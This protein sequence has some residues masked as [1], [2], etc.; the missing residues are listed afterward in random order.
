EPA[1]LAETDEVR[2]TPEIRAL[3]AKLGNHPVQ[4]YN[5]ARNNVRYTPGYG[6]MQGSAATLQGLRGN[7][8]DTAS[9]L[10]AL[11]RAAGIPSRFVYG[12]VEVPLARMQRWLGV[13]DAAA[14]QALLLAAGI[15]HQSLV[16]GGQIAAI[17]FEHVWVRAHADFSPSRGA[18]GKSAGDWVSLDASFKLSQDKAALDLR[19]AV[20]LNEP[21]L[22]D[23][24][25]AG[26]TCLPDQARDL[27]TLTLESGYADFQN[28]LDGYL[29]QQGPDLSV[30]DVLGSSAIGA[31]NFSILLGTLP[32]KTIAVG[33]VVQAL[34]HALRWQYRFQLFA[35]G[36]AQAQGQA[37]AELRGSFAEL[38]GKRITLSFAPASEA[39]AATLA[40]YMPQAHADGSAIA[41]AEFPAGLP[42]YLIRL[43]AEL[44]ADGVLVSSG[45]SFVPGSA[46]LADIGAFEP[47]TGGW[48]ERAVTV[49]AGDYHAVAIDA[50]GVAGARLLEVKAR[51][52][53]TAGKVAA[54]QAASLSRDDLAGDVLYQTALAFFATADAN[55][56]VF[57]R[58]ANVVAQRLP[59]YGRA[60]APVRAYTMLGIINRIDFP[61]VTL[62]IDRMDSAVAART[63]GLAPAAFQRQSN[64]RDA[65]YARLVL[66]KMFTDAQHPA[67]TV[68]AINALARASQDGQTIHA[69]TPA[70]LAAVLPLLTLRANAKAALVDAVG[71]GY[72]VLLARAPVG[73]GAWE[74][75]ALQIED[76]AT[77]AGSYQLLDDVGEATANVFP[78]LGMGW[79]AL[80]QP[81]QSGAALMP[82]LAAGQAIDDTLAGML[83]QATTRWS[84]FAG[85]AD[86]GNGMFLARLAAMQG[87]QACDTVVGILAAN[88]GTA[89]G[90][91]E[92][93]GDAAAVA[94]PV[95]TS[96]PVGAA[97][98][99][100]AYRYAATFNDPR[101]LPLTWRLVD[102]PAGMTVN[103]AGLVAWDKPVAGMFAVTLRADNGRAYAD[104]RYVV[105]V[106]AEVLPLEISLAITPAIV[107]PGDTVTVTMLT[108]GGSG[109]ATATVTVDGQPV[110]L[111]GAGRAVIGAGAPGAHQIVVRATDSLGTIEKTSFY[112]VRV[113]GDIT[114]PLSA[115]TS[116]A[117]DVEVTAPVNIVG[118]AFD[119]NL[120]YY[121]LLLRPAGDE[122]WQEIGRGTASVTAGVLGKLD[123]T[124][125]HNGIYELALNVVDAN[126]AKTS[127]LVTVDIYRDMKIGQFAITFEDLNVEAAG[128]PIRVTRTYD[129]R[130]KGEN[131]DFGYGW[132]VDYQSVQVRKNMVLG[133]QWKLERRQLQNCLMPVGS[134]KVNVTLPDGKVER[135]IAANT[136]ECALVNL[137]PIDIVLN[138][139]PGTTSRMEMTNLPLL[140]LRNEQIYDVD[141]GGPWNPKHFKLTTE[142]NYIYY[143]TEGIG[144]VQIKDPAGHTLTYGQNGILH[145]NG[146]S[147]AFTRD[148]NKRITAITDPAGKQIRYAYNGAGD[149]VGVTD[150]NESV[151]KFAY[152]RSHGLT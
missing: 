72:R 27:N 146:Q 120:A 94:A 148:A 128:I 87:A 63:G 43:K 41:P 138:A 39:D 95:I 36:A 44:R 1:D 12:T 98:A 84:Y 62:D 70:N 30:G 107:N 59:S 113:D 40:S 14:V 48:R 52:A 119:A 140:T 65:G 132:S 103:S 74:G 137:P 117:D 7:A 93:D 56:E 50:Q 109:G 130:R 16:A 92:A 135:F 61:G 142:D 78:A 150:R 75:H 88:L 97:T 17:Q 81:F 89:T 25:K 77:G 6:V 2:L 147:V 124:Q 51:L 86:V 71:A 38:G 26:A 122:A 136:Q 53:A 15:P 20:A 58:T 21:G 127:S 106:G 37:T 66:A 29:A 141:S 111:D 131:L 57:Q 144:I 118:T 105:S 76:P 11:N 108:N 145:S 129:T 32:Y 126:G 121:Q 28:R 33:A 8:Y 114:A 83:G 64:Q 115:I 69:V 13:Q 49:R 139:L 152:N 101:G 151:S 4:I 123:P 73:V 110:A 47:G 90:Y 82:A 31:E 55:A 112:S 5:W 67:T 149:M 19:A 34:P 46:L 18:V 24:V 96:V 79:L 116:P 133:Q 80:A 100:Q 9:L 104:Q 99:G 35:D 91:D 23:G 68:S 102:A 125:L 60:V 22:L 3:A 85:K 143:L 54:G 134:R 10:I 45:G 42:A